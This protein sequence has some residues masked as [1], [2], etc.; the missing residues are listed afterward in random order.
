MTIFKGSPLL[1]GQLNYNRSLNDYTRKVR[2]GIPIY[3]ETYITVPV[4]VFGGSTVMTLS[5]YQKQ[6]LNQEKMKRNNL[7]VSSNLYH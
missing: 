5:Q 3:Y 1:M 6:L 4:N 7:F 2:F